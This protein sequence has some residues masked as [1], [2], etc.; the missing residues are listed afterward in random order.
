ME[1]DLPI[2][3]DTM[4]FLPNGSVMMVLSGTENVSCDFRSCCVLEDAFR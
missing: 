1:V 3:S 4:N 2:K